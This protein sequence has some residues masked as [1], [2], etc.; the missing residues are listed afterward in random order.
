[1][2]LSMSKAA[3]HWTDTEA[4][5]HAQTKH[6]AHTRISAIS[7]SARELIL[8]PAAL[9]VFHQEHRFVFLSTRHPLTTVHLAV[10]TKRNQSTF[11]RI[12]HILPLS[13]FI[14]LWTI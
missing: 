11:M 2:V 3:S 12:T 8:C 10:R 5:T 4:R 1:M 9:F 7:P 6:L 14:V 13:V